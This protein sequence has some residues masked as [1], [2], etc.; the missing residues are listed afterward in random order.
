MNREDLAKMMNKYACKQLA[1]GNI[2]TCPARLSYPNLFKKSESNGGEYASKYGATLLFPKGAKLALLQDTV[3][4]IA[5]ED[6]GATVAMKSLRLPFRDQGEKSDK[7]GYEDGAVFFRANS[8]QRP[9]V[10]GPDGRPLTDEREIYPGCWVLATIRFFSYNQKGRGIAAGLQN[11]AKIAD[12]EPFGA[13]N[14]DPNEEFADVLDGAAETNEM[15]G[16]DE[17]ETHDFG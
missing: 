3:K 10:L 5:I 11:I 13:V 15:F 6:F 4:K 1:T 12:D 8:D 7:P 9:G 17:D 2:R 14:A 16:S